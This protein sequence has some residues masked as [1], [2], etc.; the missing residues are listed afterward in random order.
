MQVQN[1]TFNINIDCSYNFTLCIK[2][3]R[4]K[5][6]W[7]IKH[8]FELY[9]C[10]QHYKFDIIL[11]LLDIHFSF[12]MLRIKEFLN[13]TSMITAVCVHVHVHALDNYVS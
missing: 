4:K 12:L 10:S 11:C 7:E 9:K 13:F 2:Y 6:L 8:T 5:A 1:T 3:G